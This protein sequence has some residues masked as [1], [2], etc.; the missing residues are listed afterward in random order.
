MTRNELIQS[1]LVKGVL[2]SPCI[3]KALEE[4]DRKRF[5]PEEY[6]DFAYDD[7]PLPIG[8]GQTIS[9][10]YTM[11]FMLELLKPERGERIMD[12]GS[13][14]GWQAALLAEIVG[15]EGKVYSIEMVPFL[16]A[17]GKQNVAQF[18][19][20]ESRV[21]F[22]CRNAADGLPET[23]RQIGGFDGII[24]AAEV[25]DVPE[26]WRRQLRTGGRLVYPQA[27]SLFV[28]IKSEDGTF[29]VQSYP[30]FIFVPFVE[31]S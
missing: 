29:R 9:Q 25:R 14:S 27:G 18:P 4:V 28:E 5:V 19:A 12:I 17:A 10:P 31:E 13:G 11:A 3:Q 7:T 21:E 30:G 24:V 8:E 16:C 26:A 20:L 1:L 23:A 6:A 22:Y 2:R 15:T